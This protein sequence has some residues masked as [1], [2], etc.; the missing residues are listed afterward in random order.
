MSRFVNPVPQFFLD[1]GS[2]ASSGK[3]KFFENNDYSAL[4]D[5]FSQ[6]DN[7]I[8][9]TN[10]VSLDGQGRL[11]ACFGDGLYS[12]KFYSYNPNMPD[13]IGTLQWSRDNVALSEISGQFSDWNGII[14]YN[15]GD[16]TKAVDG[17][18]YQSIRF[19]NKGNN[20]SLSPFFWSKI[21]FIEQYNE[22]QTYFIEDIVTNS[23]YLYRSNIDNNTGN[24]PPSSQWDN[25]TFN[26][27]VVGD[28]SVSGIIT[29]ASYA[30]GNLSKTTDPGIIFP[31]KKTSQTARASTTTL[32]QDPDLIISSLLA[33]TYYKFHAYILWDGNGSTSNG[34]K[35][36]V[37]TS[38][39]VILSEI[40]TSN[41]NTSS[42][43]SSSTSNEIGGIPA[44]YNKLPNAAGA[45]EVIL[46]EGVIE[47]I[48]VSTIYVEWSQSASNATTTRLNSGSHLTVTKI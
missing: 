23:G 45:Q 1:D 34:I 27:S 2:V 30:G 3:I 38:S 32:T 25:L 20:P 46:I 21:V 18:Y 44:G 19:P 4:K 47:T 11:P 14:N 22:N 48:G 12:V 33:S 37:A 36:R 41:T 29:A 31:A 13:G 8:A 15:S 17:F 9:N 40:F 6:P 43:N 28:F 26:N 16:I 42:S 5:T 10:P 39:G 35:I 7:T 24:E